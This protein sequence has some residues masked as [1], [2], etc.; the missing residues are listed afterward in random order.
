MN[1][2]KK[3]FDYEIKNLEHEISKLIRTFS[4]GSS[5]VNTLISKNDKDFL[6]LVRDYI[7][8]DLYEKHKG[9]Y[10]VIDQYNSIIAFYEKANKNDPDAFPYTVVLDREL[11]HINTCIKIMEQNDNRFSMFIETFNFD[12]FNEYYD[13]LF[14]NVREFIVCFNMYL[15]TI[16]NEDDLYRILDKLNISELFVFKC[17][18]EAKL[19]LPSVQNLRINDSVDKDTHLKV[20][21]LITKAYERKLTEAI[22]RDIQRSR[23]SLPIQF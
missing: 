2:S 5:D 23:F 14:K 4:C 15:E 12:R 10:V 7:A 19:E 9:E 18:S 11:L 20:N 21:E 22:S 16:F 13:Y 6:E 1:K 3:D 17:F 8:N